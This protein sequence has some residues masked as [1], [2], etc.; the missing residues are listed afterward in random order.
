MMIGGSMKLNFLLA[1]FGF[2][3]TSCYCQNSERDASLD[4]SGYK[5]KLVYSE[6]FST[7]L[8]NW[9][10]E[11]EKPT[12]SKM[13]IV[14]SK[15]DVYASKGATIWFKNKLSGNVIITY[16][17]TVVNNGGQFDRVSD[18]NAF[19]M[20]SNPANENLFNQDGKFSSYDSLNLY[21]A[22]IGGHENSTTRFRKYHSNGEKPVLKEFTDKEHLLVGNRKYSVKIIVNKGLVK[23]YLNNVLFWS[24]QDEK[25]YAEGYFGF[26]TTDSHQQFDNF[27]VYAIE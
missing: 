25:P 5:T 18:L 15:M 17:V 6:D 27:N 8:A 23:F 10:A 16:I 22:G 11:F 2:F 3:A 4:N 21:Y 14:G 7:N 19:W 26:R 20:A 13:M 1:V 12:I 9:K 24:F